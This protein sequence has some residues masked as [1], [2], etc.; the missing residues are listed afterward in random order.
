[1]TAV[2]A[3]TNPPP[4]DPGDASPAPARRQLGDGVRKLPLWLTLVS[5]MLVL[6][7]GGVL[8]SDAIVTISFQRSVMNRIDQDITGVAQR[9]A[10]RPLKPPIPPGKP[11]PSIGY[12]SVPSEPSASPTP[13][14]GAPS[15]PPTLRTLQPPPP[16]TRPNSQPSPDGAPEPSVA[17]ITLEG[18]SSSRYYIRVGDRVFGRFRGSDGTVVAPQIPAD[19]YQLRTPQTVPSEGDPRLRWRAVWIPSLHGDIVVA[20]ELTDVDGN[21]SSLLTLQLAIGTGVLLVLGLAGYFLVRWSLRPLVEVERTAN[22]IAAGNL[23][24]RVPDW[25]ERTEVGRLSTALNSMLAQ[26]QQAFAATQASEEKAKSSEG[27]MRQFVADASHE[28]RTPLT[29][30][31]GFAELHRKGVGVSTAVAMSRIESEAIRMGKLVE[32]LLALA[33]TDEQRPLELEPVDMFQLMTDA[34]HDAKAIAPDREV[35]FQLQPSGGAPV[36]LGDEPCLRQVLSNLVSNALSHTGDEASVTLWLGGDAQD[37]LLEVRDTGPGLSPEDAERIFER[38]Y[39]VDPSR[40]RS[41]GG[42]GLGLAIVDAIVRAHGGQASVSSELGAGTTL[43]VRLPRLAPDP[44]ED[45]E[46]YLA[47]E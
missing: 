2:R 1:M 32:D 5:L 15:A 23:E 3:R 47:E 40:A 10:E 45:D 35:V 4:G 7:G 30:I 14:Q 43:R 39:R 8:V 29:A 38:F 44:E 41:S 24:R 28:L 9:I 21:L 13:R 22:E 11:I 33:R 20:T 25:G 42:S 31:R 17:P 37:V 18:A 6:V 46:L 19:L 26:I 36:V 12:P 34:V 16:T 27:R